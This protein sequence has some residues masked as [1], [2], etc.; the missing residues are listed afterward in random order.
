MWPCPPRQ[1]DRGRATGY[2]SP[3]AKMPEPSRVPSAVAAM[4]VVGGLAKSADAQARWMQDML[5]QNARMISQ[6]PETLRS[7]NDAIERFN[8]TVGRLDR[9]VTRIETASK[10]LTGPMERVAGALDRNAFRE[11]PET[12]DSLRREAGPALRAAADTQR[13]VATLQTTVERVITLVSEIPGA[14]ILRRIAAGRGEDEP[15][16]PGPKPSRPST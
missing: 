1:V 7:F 5:E 3:V 4:P 11:L 16:K 8:Q 9:A 13:Q 12:L 2:E 10:N 6:F 15:N 14:G